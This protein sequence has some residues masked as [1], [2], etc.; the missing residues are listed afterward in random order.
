MH[1]LAPF[2]LILGNPPSPNLLGTKNVM[3]VSHVLHDPHDKI[4]VVY[5]LP[6][7]FHRPIARLPDT[8]WRLSESGQL[9]GDTSIRGGVVGT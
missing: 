7:L 9:S 5:F 1:K 3:S 4:P 2:S 6:L 8:G